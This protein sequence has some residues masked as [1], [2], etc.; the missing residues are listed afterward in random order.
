[1]CRT[2]TPSQTVGPFFD[3]G[4]DHRRRGDRRAPRHAGP[5]TSSSKGRSATAPA[6]RVPDALVEIWQANAAGRYRHPADDRGRRRST[7]R[8]TASA[9][10]A[11]DDDGRFA[12]TTVHA[13]PRAGTGRRAAGAAP[14]RQRPRAR[15]A[16]P[17]RHADLLRGRARER[18]RTRCSRSCPRDRRATLIAQRD[19]A[20]P[21]PLRHRA[22]GTG[23]DG[24]L[25]C[26]TPADARAQLLR[27]GARSRPCST[28]RPRS[29]RRKPRSA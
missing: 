22:P 15:R 25:R 29:R 17:A 23:R 3:F 13:G 24:V 6:I 14:A 27:R 2:L 10:C 19:G 21:L 11:T 16:H 12:F 8:S 9:G 1:M 26:L 18:T 28:S 4:L 20:G 7:R 5:R